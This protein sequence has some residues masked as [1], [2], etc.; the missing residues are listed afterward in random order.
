MFGIIYFGAA[1]LPQYRELISVLKEAD[2]QFKKKNYVKAIEMYEGVWEYIKTDKSRVLKVAE[3][4]FALGNDKKALKK[5]RGI[6]LNEE[7][8][9][10]LKSFMPRE[11]RALFTSVRRR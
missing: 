1:F 3:T 7:N 11:Y 2:L 9:K 5:L 6:T 8:W 10:L 4:Y